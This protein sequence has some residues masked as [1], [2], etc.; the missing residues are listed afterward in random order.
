VPAAAA[1]AAGRARPRA[2]ARQRCELPGR[3]L[4]KSL[5]K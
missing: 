1:A 5:N 3:R 2:A 4:G